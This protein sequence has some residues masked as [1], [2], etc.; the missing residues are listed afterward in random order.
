MSEHRNGRRFAVPACRRLTWDLLHFNRLVP[1]CGHDRMCDLSSVAAARASCATR[2]SWPAVFLKAFAVVAQRVPELRQ[3]WY[4]WPWAHLFQHSRSVGLV[5]VQRQ[6]RDE[7]WLFW[8]RIAAPETLPLSEIQQRIDSFRSDDP[9]AVFQRQLQLAALPTWLRRMVWWW[10][11]N[12][13]TDRRAKRL[14]TFFL[15]TLASRGAE[16]QVPPSIH[17]ACLTYGP[18]DSDGRCRVTLAYDHRV[19]DGALIADCLRQV[20]VTLSTVIRE[21]LSAMSSGNA[22]DAAA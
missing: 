5:T 10:N 16:I 19:M 11:L 20:E 18:L 6:F 12:V 3:T 8:G 14:G 9:E 1:Q 13:A 4:R 2:I 7:P 17:T 22:A 15:S 21:E